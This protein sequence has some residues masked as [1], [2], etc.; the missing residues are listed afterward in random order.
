MAFNLIPL[1]PLDGAQVLKSLLS[2]AGAAQVSR[3]DPIGPF[4][5]L[6][7]IVMGRAT[8]SSVIGM[9]INPVIGALSQVVTGGLL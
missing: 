3:L 6:G 9:L 2:P 4:L 7:L 1:H 8:G 5:L